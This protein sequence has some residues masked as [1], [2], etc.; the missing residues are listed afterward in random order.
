MKK[1]KAAHAVRW[2]TGSPDAALFLWFIYF[3][4]CTRIRYAFIY[5]I[6]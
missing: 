6:E 3:S 4:M 2:Y 5:T 1:N